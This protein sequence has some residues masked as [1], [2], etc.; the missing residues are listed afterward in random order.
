MRVEKF[1]LRKKN[2]IAGSCKWAYDKRKEGFAMHKYYYDEDLA[3][4]FKISP[5]VASVVENDD[6]GA[7][8]AI[9]VHADIKVT[10]FKR[11]KV[12]RTISEVYPADRYNPDSAKK[13]F[14]D[15]VLQQVLGN[16]VAISKEEY[17]ALKMRLEPASYCN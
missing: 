9:L 8:A 15:T 16:A 11:E 6:T 5:V 2:I 12:R 10:N 17:E 14:T 13:V 1:V 4:V 7:P 3:L